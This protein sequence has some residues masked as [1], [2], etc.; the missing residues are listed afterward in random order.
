VR[1]ACEVCAARSWFRRTKRPDPNLSFRNTGGRAS[2]SVRPPNLRPH[3]YLSSL[4]T[5]QRDRA[6][7]SRMMLET[8]HHCARGKNCMKLLNYRKY[9]FLFLLIMH[10][11][12]HTA[13]EYVLLLVW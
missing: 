10:S 6:S 11:T 9:L 3:C 7:H 8:S 2:V 4:F 12:L 5:W 1:G 13:V